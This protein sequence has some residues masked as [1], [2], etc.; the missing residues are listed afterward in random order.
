MQEV[1]GRGHG[2]A[3]VWEPDPRV[4][5]P[6]QETHGIV[7][8]KIWHV[9]LEEKHYCLCWMSW[10]ELRPPSESVSHSVVSNSVTPW[11][12]ACQ[13]P[14]SI[15]FSR[16]EYWSGLLFPSAGGPPDPG[17]KPGTPELLGDSLPSEPKS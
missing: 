2:K 1:G 16:Q 10:I 6:K 11:T 4:T 13:A 14:L 5:G 8:S 7:T 9:T 12:V 15:E 17:I 3:G